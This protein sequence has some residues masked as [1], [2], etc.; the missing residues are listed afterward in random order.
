LFWLAAFI[1]GGGVKT[2]FMLSR[3]KLIFFR[4]RLANK[5]FGDGGDLRVCR[6]RYDFN[7]DFNITSYL[8]PRAKA[9]HRTLPSFHY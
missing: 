5:K 2:V 1:F 4:R 6:Q 8:R 3:L 9:F 7:G